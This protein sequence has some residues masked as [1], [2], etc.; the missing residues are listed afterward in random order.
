V[1]D[2][3]G[4]LLLAI[5][6]GGAL[7]LWR[8]GAQSLWYDE[9]LTTRAVAGTLRDLLHHVGNR[10][11]IAPT[12]FLGMWGWVRVFGDGETA[13]RAVS[14]LIGTA[15]VPVAYAI[16][17][18]LGQRRAGAR[19][20]ASLVAVSP[21]LVWYSQEARPYSLVAFMGALSFL[22]FARLRNR[23]RRR[24]FVSWALVC[25]CTIAIHY[26]AV[27]IVAAEA[28]GLLLSRP[29]QRRQ[30][31]LSCVPG[32]VVLVALA[33]MA[34]AQYGH[35]ANRQWISGFSLDYRLREAGRSSL[36][37]PNPLSGRLWIA[38][39]IVVLIS[40]LLLLTRAD[41]NERSA[42]GVAAAVGGVAVLMPLG[43]VLVGVDVVLSRYLI[44]SLVPLIVAV[45]IGLAVCGTRWVGGGAAAIL[46]AVSL[47]AVV[48]VARDPQLQR[49]D[50]REVVRVFDTGG[51]NR[52]LLLSTSGT[53][54]SPLLYYANDVRVLG[55]DERARVDEIDVLSVK[56]TAKPCNLLVGRACA[57]IYLGAPLPASIAGDFRL[58]TRY[59]LPQFTVDRYRAVRTQHLTKAQLVAPQNLP[60]SLALLTMR[61]AP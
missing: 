58:E 25:A 21:M 46:F 57:M 39:A 23:G 33:P 1:G 13:L 36:V 7:R 52:T 22:A 34:V 30:V 29:R 59:R 32:A 26:F 10:E 24:D 6:A 44:A 37:G 43:A 47:A 49:P 9:W 51:P 11:G 28:I 40:V 12:Y 54:A 60:D 61:S 8:L 55:G 27:F 48:G 42:A 14:A 20:A 19:I 2:L 35:A 18:E 31:L 15:T 16:A 4:V 3:D 5:A 53:I 45:A 41:R 17:R 50:W 56:P 38:A